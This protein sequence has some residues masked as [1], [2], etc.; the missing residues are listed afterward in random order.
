MAIH[1]SPLSL[2]TQA[3]LLVATLSQLS[4]VS[5]QFGLSV[6]CNDCLVGQIGTLPSCAGVNLTSADAKSSPQYKTCLCDSSFDFGWTAPCASKCQAN[7]LTTFQSNYG[8]LLKSANFVCVKP[9]PSPS[10]SPTPAPQS[11]AS[12][13]QAA[14]VLGWTVMGSVLLCLVSGL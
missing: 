6:A 5:A 11:A 14:S 12:S 10:P 8:N 7:E 2:T 4:P 1:R 9:T 13:L 3:L